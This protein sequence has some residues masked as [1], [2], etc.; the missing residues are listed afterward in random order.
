[1]LRIIGHVMAAGNMKWVQDEP[2]KDEG[3]EIILPFNSSNS[4]YISKGGSNKRQKRKILK[5]AFLFFERT[6]KKNDVNWI[7][8]G[9]E[10]WL[11]DLDLIKEIYPELSL[12]KWLEGKTIKKPEIIIKEKTVFGETQNETELCFYF[13]EDNLKGKNSRKS[14]SKESNKNESNITSPTAFISYAW[15]NEEMKKWVKTLAMQLRSDGVDVK[16]DQW[17]LVPGEQIPHFMENSVRENDYVLIICTPTYKEKSEK[18]IGGVGYEGDIMTAEVLQK[19]NH[20]KFI[21]ILKSGNKETAIPSWLQGKYFINLSNDEYFEKNYEDLRTTL[22]NIRETAPALGSF[23][24]KAK[25]NIRKTQLPKAKKEED[26]IKIKGILVDEVTEPLNDGTR[27][28]ALYKIPFELNKRPS[29]D[30]IN[31]FIKAWNLPPESSNMHRPGIASV[32][33]NKIVL[34]GTTIEEVE[35]YHKDTLK[36]AVEV[37]NKGIKKIRMMN[38]QK[39]ELEKKRKKEH[40]KKIEDISKKINFE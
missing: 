32:Y 14:P 21:P 24:Q 17:E 22:L 39:E 37:A 2:N 40:R 31:L 7:S 11:V 29:K 35:K 1:M 6:F 27:G 15:E 20:K 8:P 13:D 36:L 4:D 28:S 25:Q 10:N 16:L 3:L 33:G 19:S 9:E 34:D 23:T 12:F 5:E 26:E 30:W 18:R 38:R